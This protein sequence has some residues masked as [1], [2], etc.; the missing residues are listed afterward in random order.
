MEFLIKT[1]D[2]NNASELE[3][4]A[5]HA[6]ENRIRRE[7]WP[8]DSP[9]PLEEI[10][11]NL[12]FAPPLVDIHLWAAWHADGKAILGRARLMTYRTEQNRH[13][14]ESDIAVLSEMRRRGI[15]RQ[16]LKLV[17]ERARQEDRRVLQAHTDAHVPSGEA[18]MRRLGARMGM[19]SHTNQLD[20]THL[21]RDLIRRWQVSAPKAE[22]ELGL[23]EG[24]YPEEQIDSVVELVKVMNT[25]PR[26][27]LELEDWNWT[28]DDL[29]AWQRSLKQR[30]VEQ[31]TLCAREMATG[32]FAGYTEVFWNPYH[33]EVLQQGDTGVFPKYR[34]RGLGRWL[35]AA[36]L[37]KILKDRPYVKRI[38][39]G[40]ADSNAPMLKIN[41][42]LEFKPYKSWC[43]WQVDLDRVFEYLGAKRGAEA[44]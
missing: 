36:M 23:W 3:F 39:T 37:E 43:T 8:E 24:T 18:F 25:E 17:A 2:P 26:D 4:A 38:R 44:Y 5:L 10:I 41:Y 27:E 40:N 7:Q 11:Q 14:A 13:L 6:F 30:K 33:P 9:F 20:L 31:W 19:A 22:F 15:A 12:R 16:F 42:E 21:D 28:A 32:E 1:F 35:K 29:R 34:N